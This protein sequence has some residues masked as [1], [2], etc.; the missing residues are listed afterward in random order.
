MRGTIS[1]LAARILRDPDLTKQL[2]RA[3]MAGG[4]RITVDGKTYTVQTS[5]TVPVT[6]HRTNEK[7]KA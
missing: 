4:G 7:G 1:E 5:R 2:D 6:V 3:V